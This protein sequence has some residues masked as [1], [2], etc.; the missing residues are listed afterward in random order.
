VVTKGDAV[1]LLEKKYLT[2]ARQ[3]KPEN[4]TAQ[5][6]RIDSFGN[7]VINKFKEALALSPTTS[8]TKNA[9]GM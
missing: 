1:E 8:S 5:S 3:N 9:G 2:R 6:S 7:Q 4:V